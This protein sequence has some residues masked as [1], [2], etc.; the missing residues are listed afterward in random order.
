M[1]I[2]SRSHRKRQE[3][4]H[5]LTQKLLNNMKKQVW[6]LNFVNSYNCKHPEQ[7]SDIFIVA[8]LLSV[9]N[10]IYS[11]MA[12]I[13]FFLHITRMLHDDSCLQTDIHNHRCSSLICMSLS[14]LCIVHN[15]ACQITRTL[16]P[17]SVTILWCHESG[18]L[19]TI[20]RLFSEY[21][22][23]ARHN[24]H[25]VTRKLSIKSVYVSMTKCLQNNTKKRVKLFLFLTFP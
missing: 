22:F 9:A 24:S 14:V 16:G 13:D 21:V 20:L 10:Y 23:S 18:C 17:V 6:V 5:E 12:Y 3:V 19:Y 8:T 11:I 2:Y 7:C 1:I 15:F 25:S 4:L